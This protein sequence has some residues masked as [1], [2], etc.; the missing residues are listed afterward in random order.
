M[1]RAISENFMKALQ[2]GKLQAVKSIIKNDISLDLELCG[3]DVVVYY[4]GLKILTITEQ[5]NGDFKFKEL[6]PKYIRRKSGLEPNLPAWNNERSNE[7]FMQAKMIIDTYDM[8]S[9]WEYEI[10]Q[11]V[12]RE[13]NTSPNAN[14][15]DFWVIDT[16]YQND[17]RNQ[18][19]IVALHLDSSPEARRKGVASIAMIEIK[20][21][22]SALHSSNRN[23]GILTHLEDFQSHLANSNRVKAFISDMKHVFEQKYQLG[24]INGLNENVVNRLKMSNEVEFYVLLA[25]Y[26]KASSKLL[27]ELKSFPEDCNFLTSFFAGYGLYSHSIKSKDEII[28]LL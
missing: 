5:E 14:D 26:K 4:K 13:N 24:M 18:F 19:D 12:I 6:D 10:K 3:K 8:R 11:M 21:G 9:C 17:D 15:T 7:Y 20:Q 1:T 2:N 22:V 23:P 16:E 27:D 28:E 25:N